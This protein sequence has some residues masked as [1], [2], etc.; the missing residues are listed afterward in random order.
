MGLT[1]L[2]MMWLVLGTSV[3]AFHELSETLGVGNVHSLFTAAALFVAGEAAIT[4]TNRNLGW[5][6]G[7]VVAAPYAVPGS[8]LSVLGALTALL[9]VTVLVRVRQRAIPRGPVA[10]STRNPGPAS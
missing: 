5:F 10:G 8:Y 4:W 9:A 7:S 1:G 6:E 2:M 3:L